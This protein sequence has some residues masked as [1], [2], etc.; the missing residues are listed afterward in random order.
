MCEKKIIMLVCRWRGIRGKECRWP[1]KTENYLR[2]T[3]SKDVRPQN[4]N[5][6]ELNSAN[7]AS[8]GHQIE[9]LLGK[10]SWF[11]LCESPIREASSVFSDGWITGLWAYKPVLFQAATLVGIC[12]TEME[13]KYTIPELKSHQSHL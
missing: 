9:A 2:L 1:L 10:T 7:R 3:A 11:W 4:Y 8:R 6:N 5:S 12:Y 13:I